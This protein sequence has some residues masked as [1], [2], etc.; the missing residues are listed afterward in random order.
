MNWLQY[1]GWSDKQLQDLRFLGYS[2]FSQGKFDIAI[3]FFE[4]LLVLDNENV[5]DLQELGA[6]YLEKGQS[7]KALDYLDKALKKDPSYL[8]SLVN[9]TKALFSLGYK[10]QGLALARSLLSCGD[11]TIE[12]LAEALI[13]AYK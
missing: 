4:G 5:Y 2:Y 12:N 7:L 9:K 1:L 3:N 6:L 8:P 11:K 13:L 10:N